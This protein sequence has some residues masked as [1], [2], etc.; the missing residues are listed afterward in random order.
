MVNA[1]IRDRLLKRLG[2][3]SK[4][5]LS[6]R[7]QVL[8]A[9]YGPMSTDDA[10]YVI[11][12]LQGIDLSRDLPLATQDRI[13]TLIPRELLG[14]TTKRGTKRKE[15]PKTKEKG[16][17]SSYPLVDA[18]TIQTAFTLGN[19]VFPQVFILEN[20]IRTFISNT[21]CGLS[22][23]WWTKYVPMNVQKS[24]AK[25]MRK[26]SR[27]PY[28]RARGNHP[29]LYSNFADLKLI[30]LANS[31]GAFSDVLIK[32]DWFTAGMDDV[33]MARNNLAHSI[34]LDPSDVDHIRL[35]AHEWSILLEVVLKSQ[36][37]RIVA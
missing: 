24:V 2:G 16:T 23:D 19:N 17:V 1:K 31:E 12:H 18:E 9:R 36:A 30:I 15:K 27:Y 3:I 14:D 33:Y 32:P 8:K 20:S 5:A 11:A 35:F 37:S 34:P 6:Q 26:E 22:E 7:V 28:R 25:T 21:L 10:V 4:Q 13:R 29:L